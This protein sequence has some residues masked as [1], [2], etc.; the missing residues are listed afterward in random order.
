MN[1]DREASSA[2]NGRWAR[3]TALASALSLI[4]IAGTRLDAEDAVPAAKFV[5][6]VGVNIHLHYRDTSYGDFPR[7]E[8]ALLDLGVHHVR[9]GLVVSDWPP[10]YERLK[11]L[12]KDGFKALL[13]VSASQSGAALDAFPNR[14]PGVMEGFEAP[15][16]MDRSGPGWQQRLGAEMAAIGPVAAKWHLPLVA[17]SLT[18]PSSFADVAKVSGSAA[19]GNLHNYFGGRNPGTPG[20]GDNGYGSFGW[21]LGHAR[22]AWPGKPVWTT[23]T[24]YVMDPS[25]S[26]GIPE[27]VAARYTVRLLMEQYLHGIQRTYL[28]E[29]LDTEIPAQGVRDR[30]GLVRSDFTPK[31]AYLAVQSLLHLLADPGGEAA[32]SLDVKLLG[33]PGDLHHMLFSKR[34]GEFYLMLWVE[35]PSYDVDRKTDLPVK[36]VHLRASWTGDRD[37]TVS[38]IGDDGRFSAVG[39]QRG[40][41]VALAVD[42]RVT[43][44]RIR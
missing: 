8:R 38:R 31:P 41:S 43:V 5:E 4:L 29:L 3:R 27:A 13:I 2:R 34:N 42:D 20:W 15:N 1:G 7:V 18:E 12:R 30:F 9:D 44:V 26:Q 24:G 17:P 16:E 23:E 39:A 33:A 6:S 11:T 19:F 25:M 28:Y 37:A 36:T 40:A 22:E 10:Y 35:E 21:S 32:A 14:I